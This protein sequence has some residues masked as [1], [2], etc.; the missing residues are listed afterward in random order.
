MEKA[1]KCFDSLLN[2]QQDEIIKEILLALYYLTAADAP[3]LELLMK[4]IKLKTIVQ[5]VFNENKKIQVCAIKIIGNLCYTSNE[6][7]DKF[8][9][10]GCLSMLKFVATKKPTEVSVAREACWALSNIAFGSPTHIQQLIGA[11]V[12]KAMQKILNEN[13]DNTIK[14]EALWVLANACMA[15]NNT[16]ALYLVNE[17]ILSEF[18]LM[19]DKAAATTLNH[20]LVVIDKILGLG[21][22]GKVNKIADEWMTIG[23]VEKM[24]KLQEH[25]NERIYNQVVTILEK[26]YQL[27]CI[28]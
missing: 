15:G 8:I 24:E 22:T 5:L 16:Q 14:E 3:Y 11:G 21:S 25:E 6:F 9:A 4:N 7:I 23:G 2:S 1:Y 28:N 20:L 26:H 12:L 18:T 27:E 17:G 10:N 19:L 13:Y